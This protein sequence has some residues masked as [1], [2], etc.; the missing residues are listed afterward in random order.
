MPILHLGQGKGVGN[1]AASLEK[2][3]KFGKEGLNCIENCT[4]VFAYHL[5]SVA[6]VCNGNGVE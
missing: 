1:L 3:R 6:A 5:T 4:A 2:K